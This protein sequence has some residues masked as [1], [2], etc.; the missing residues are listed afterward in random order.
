[1]GNHLSCMSPA[2]AP[3]YKRNLIKILH[4]ETSALSEI[5]GPL[6]AAEVMMD[7]PAQFLCCVSGAVST[8][9]RICAV[10]ADEELRASELYILLPMHK[11]N[12]RFSA[13][14]MAY[15][16]MRASQTCRKSSVGNMV[17]GSA[18]Q[19]KVAPLPADQISEG[20]RAHSIGS[21]SFKQSSKNLQEPAPLRMGVHNN[22]M[23]RSKSWIP[24]LETIREAPATL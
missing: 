22:M 9:R 20:F 10:P 19:S 14:D 13:D 3:N 24:K 8:G 5:E 6:T 2:A 4:S 21:Q 18:S 15:L 23:C 17:K 16:A 11:L 7:F 1:M 12:T